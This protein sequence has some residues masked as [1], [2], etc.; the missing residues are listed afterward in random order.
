MLVSH[1]VLA[2]SGRRV[3]L[4]TPSALLPAA[5]RPPPRPS[6]PPPTLEPPFFYPPFPPSP[7]AG[8]NFSTG[9]PISLMM[10]EGYVRVD[11]LTSYAYVGDGIGGRQL[12]ASGTASGCMGDAWGIDSW[13]QQ[14]CSS[15]V[16]A[17]DQPAE[18]FMVYDPANPGA[19]TLVVSGETVVLVSVRVR[20]RPC[21]V[22]SSCCGVKPQSAE[23]AHVPA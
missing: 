23:A 18:K 12:C 19:T 4:N 5:C 10:D 17:G 14:P 13:L 1:C 16:T 20:G 21:S 2:A 22:H 7:A 8:S 11:N 6:S 15:R 3:K 9:Q